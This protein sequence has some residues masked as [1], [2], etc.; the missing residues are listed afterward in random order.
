LEELPADE[1]PSEDGDALAIFDLT[2]EFLRER[3]GA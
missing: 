1:G 2:L 3:L